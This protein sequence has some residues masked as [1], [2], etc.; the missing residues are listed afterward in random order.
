MVV[1]VASGVAPSR[2]QSLLRGVRYQRVGDDLIVLLGE[3]NHIHDIMILWSRH[4]LHPLNTGGCYGLDPADSGGPGCGGECRWS[5]AWV[6]GRF[7]CDHA[8]SL[9]CLRLSGGRTAV[10][11][12]GRCCC[13]SWYGLDRLRAYRGLLVGPGI[14]A[15]LIRPRYFGGAPSAPPCSP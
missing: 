9:R 12:G 13:W 15:G 7:G 10:G 14:V 11:A 2:R 8:G 3:Q 6:Q 4:L 1:V 5:L